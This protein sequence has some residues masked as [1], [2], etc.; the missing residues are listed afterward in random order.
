MA[1]CSQYWLCEEARRTAGSTVLLIE[2]NVALKS[3][4][5]EW[6]AALCVDKT[7]KREGDSTE[8]EE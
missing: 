8:K 7:V 5:L 6:P 4:H 2:H 1:L 3:F